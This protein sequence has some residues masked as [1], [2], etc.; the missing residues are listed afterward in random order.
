MASKPPFGGDWVREIKHDGYGMIVRRDGLTVRLDSRNVYDWTARLPGDRGRRVADKGPTASR[1]VARRRYW[2]PAACHG[3]RICAE[4][5]P[6]KPRSSS[7]RVVEFDG[8]DLRDLPFLD[9]KVALAGLLGIPRRAS[10]S[11][12]Y[13]AEDRPIVF[14]HAC[15]L[16]AE[17]IVSTRAQP[18]YPFPH[19]LNSDRSKQT[20]RIKPVARGCGDARA[21]RRA[22]ETSSHLTIAPRDLP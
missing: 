21:G 19:V 7:I 13:A 20:A 12:N 1:S 14:A 10:S 2:A 16:G 11:T 4:G 5:M 22:N 15:R 9:R 3:S 6:H 17:G 8:E 18:A